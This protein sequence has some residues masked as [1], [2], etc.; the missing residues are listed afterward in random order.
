MRPRRTYMY[1]I[2]FEN[3]YVTPS[4]RWNLAVALSHS[5]Q[6]LKLWLVDASLAE[7]HKHT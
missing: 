2:M 7:I 4:A 3:V 6:R 1:M 5:A